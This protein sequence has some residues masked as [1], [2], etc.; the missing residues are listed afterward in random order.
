MTDNTAQ[1]SRDE[2]RNMRN[3]G[4]YRPV[5]N[6]TLESS[7]RFINGFHGQN[8]VI[9]YKMIIWR[10]TNEH[11]SGS[12]GRQKPSAKSLLS[13]YSCMEVPDTCM[14]LP[15]VVHLSI[16]G[17][18]LFMVVVT[19]FSKASSPAKSSPNP[20]LCYL[21]WVTV[22]TFPYFFNWYSFVSSTKEHPGLFVHVNSLK[23]QYSIFSKLP[24]HPY[25]FVPFF[26]LF[27]GWVLGFKKFWSTNF[28][29]FF[30]KIFC[31]SF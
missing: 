11:P 12:A 2:N 26:L 18:K 14:I 16:R 19:K 31:H 30:K 27:V 6:T 17:C 5:H 25:N 7:I 22:A 10:N 3:A 13:A 23:L 29:R 9:I 15:S 28:F 21:Q 4:V 8:L 24:L 1:T 20:D